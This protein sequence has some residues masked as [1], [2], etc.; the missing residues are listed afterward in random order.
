MK[1]N[2]DLYVRLSDRFLPRA[3]GEIVERVTLTLWDLA[4]GV[5]LATEEDDMLSAVNS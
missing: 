1:I 4:I 2:I 5:C 3:A